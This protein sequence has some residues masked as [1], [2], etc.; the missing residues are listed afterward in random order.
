M[1]QKKRSQKKRSQK[2]RSQKKKSQKKKSLKKK[3]LK[4]KNLK[5]LHQQFLVSLI[6]NI[7][8]KKNQ[9]KV[10]SRLLFLQIKAIN[11]KLVQELKNLELLINLKMKIRMNLKIQLMILRIKHQLH[12]K[13]Q[14][15]L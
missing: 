10:K 4:K 13:N 12:K 6:S 15:S 14:K 11:S 3:N 7:Q 5:S 9:K 2:K 8:G 1:S